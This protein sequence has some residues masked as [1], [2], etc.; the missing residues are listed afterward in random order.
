MHRGFSR[1]SG[2]VIQAG[3]PGAAALR[4]FLGQIPKE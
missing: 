2:G 3:I 1:V 4:G